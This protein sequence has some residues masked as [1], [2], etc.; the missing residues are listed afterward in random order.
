[1]SRAVPSSFSEYLLDQS[2][3]ST[4]IICD[5]GIMP[6]RTSTDHSSTWYKNCLRGEDI[7]FLKEAVAARRNDAQNYGLDDKQIKTSR[8]SLLKTQLGWLVNGGLWSDYDP[9]SHYG[10]HDFGTSSPTVSEMYQYVTGLLPTLTQ[11]SANDTYTELNSEPILN[12]F[13]DVKQLSYTLLSGGTTYYSYNGF[14]K[15]D[16]SSQHTVSVR[17]YTDGTSRTTTSDYTGSGWL[18]YQQRRLNHI[19]GSGYPSNV[20]SSETQDTT[21]SSITMSEGSSSTYRQ[22]HRYLAVKPFGVFTVYNGYDASWQDGTGD[23]AVVGTDSWETYKY[24]LAPLPVSTFVDLLNTTSITI[25]DWST[26]IPAIYDFAGLEMYADDITGSF[27]T[28]SHRDYKR[29]ITY[30]TSPSNIF[31]V[32]HFLYCNLDDVTIQ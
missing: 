29:Q 27:Q 14:Y 4:G 6:L 21:N 12:L 25:S 8:L 31:W 30:V 7:M 16:N 10:F 1:M 15:T 20:S 5:G 26:F 11:Y 17:G 24:I 18:W 2:S 3:Q 28:G 9:S 13:R 19:Y 23:Q 32:A 22:Y